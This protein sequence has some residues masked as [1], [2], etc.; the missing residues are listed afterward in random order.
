M[1]TCLVAQLDHSILR[2]AHTTGVAVGGEALS[3]ALSQH[4]ASSGEA[5]VI[6]VDGL[7][8]SMTESLLIG[9]V[10][11]HNVEQGGKRVSLVLTSLNIEVKDTR[12]VLAHSLLPLMPSERH[13]MIHSHC[14]RR[15][16]ALPGSAIDELV[17][18]RGAGNPKFLA[19]V[20]AFLAKLEDSLTEVESLSHLADDL[21]E[22][23]VFNVIPFLDQV[24]GRAFRR[25]LTLVQYEPTGLLMGELPG[26]IRGAESS[27]VVSLCMDLRDLG[28]F[29]PTA[30]VQRVKI[31]CSTV[32]AACGQWLESTYAQLKR[33]ADLS[34]SS[35]NASWANETPKSRSPL[36][37]A[38]LHKRRTYVQCEAVHHL[39]EEDKAEVY[40]SEKGS[41]THEVTVDLENM[42]LAQIPADATSRERA[43]MVTRL[44]LSSNNLTFLGKGFSNFSNLTALIACVNSF[45]K[46]PSE[47]AACTTL[48]ELNLSENQISQIPPESPLATLHRLEVLRLSL[49]KV[50]SLP[51]DICNLSSLRELHLSANRLLTLPSSIQRLVDLEVLDLSS[52]AIIEIP[53][54]HN[55][56][57]LRRLYLSS[58]RLTV[59]PSIERLTNLHDLDIESN[60]ITSM[61]TMAKSHPF[62]TNL[63][64][65]FNKLGHIEGLSGCLRLEHLNASG[66]RL[67]EIP[68]E[69]VYVLGLKSLRLASNRIK[70]VKPQLIV[71]EG[72]RTLDLS[73]N[74][75]SLLPVEVTLLTALISL[76]LSNNALTALPPE[77]VACKL[78]ARVDLEANPLDLDTATVS[79]TQNKIGKLCT[80]NGG[81]L[82]AV[83]PAKLH[84]F[85]DGNDIET[86]FDADV[87]GTGSMSLSPDRGTVASPPATPF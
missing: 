69:A 82:K 36:Y 59:L 62:L 27:Q 51:E 48:T 79:A 10:Q 9:L 53:S 5:C 61:P 83:V 40:W 14:A 17:T 31:S 58:N 70:Q 74:Q 77:I 11:Q 84:H 52:N 47:L 54:I 35:V 34:T 45:V 4:G 56:L 2:T 80:L 65:A 26:L 19:T 67:E 15:N 8:D 12:V 18:K 32:N 28:I 24:Y 46:L 6:I 3:H 66:N 60:Q 75:L 44:L 55:F 78:L 30:D 43:R 64:V 33:G 22:L 73:H 23:L 87:T 63:N 42:H 41:E 20:I 76:N 81:H 57:K 49:N 7:R 71:W 25:L 37:G 1:L 68:P 38:L 86:S 13:I 72:L 85:G 16:L 50:A 29:A 21:E 39:E